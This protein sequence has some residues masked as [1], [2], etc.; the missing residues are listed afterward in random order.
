MFHSH[1]SAGQILIVGWAR[2]LAYGTRSLAVHC[3]LNDS[4]DGSSATYRVPKNISFPKSQNL[5]IHF[6]EA[7]VVTAVPKDVRADFLQPI[8]WIRSSAELLFQSG[9]VAAM[10]K[11][12]VTEHDDVRSGEDDVGSAR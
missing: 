8:R 3:G 1:I 6:S 12:T 9:P 10:P 7:L 2:G 5:P 11:I 4:F